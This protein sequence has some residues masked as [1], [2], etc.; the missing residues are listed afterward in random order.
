[1]MPYDPN[2]ALQAFILRQNS[3]PQAYPQQSGGPGNANYWTTPFGETSVGKNKKASPMTGEMFNTL[4]WDDPYLNSI[5]YQGQNQQSAYET[6]NTQ[7]GQQFA[8]IYNQALKAYDPASIAKIYANAY[9]QLGKNQGSSVANA[10]R[11]AGMQAASGSLANPGAFVL[12]AGANARQPYANAFAELGQ[13]ESQAQLS[14][15]KGIMDT[16][17]LLNRYKQGDQT[18]LAELDLR[19]QQLELQRQQLQ[20]QIDASQADFGDYAGMAIGALSPAAPYLMFP[21][22]INNAKKIG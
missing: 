2:G 20:A 9:G 1:M 11:T 17:A 4:G 5:G 15:Q 10:Q 6:Q 21:S 14:G 18:A 13:Q 19:R 12:G 3:K 7:Q 22:L 16:M 8:D